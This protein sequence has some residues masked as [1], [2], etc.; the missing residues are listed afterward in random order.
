MPFFRSMWSKRITHAL[1]ATVLLSSM[2]AFSFIHTFTAH[3][4]STD[5][6]LSTCE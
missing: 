1:L 4:A 2:I 6:S 5:S 3:A